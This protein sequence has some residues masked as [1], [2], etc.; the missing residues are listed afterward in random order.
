MWYVYICDKEGGLY[1]G[2]TTDIPRRMRQHGASLLRS[3]RF[4]DKR[5]AAR[6]ER[7]IKGWRREKKLALIKDAAVR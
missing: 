2:I 4:Q 6:R 1:T 3:E 5:A 7:E